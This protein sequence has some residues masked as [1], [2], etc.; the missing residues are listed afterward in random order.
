MEKDA[1]RAPRE[2][3]QARGTKSRLCAVTRAEHP[4][5]NL[6]RFVAGPD[7]R[8]VP[9]LARRLPGRGVWVTATHEMVRMAAERRV[10]ARSLKTE[11]VVDLKLADLVSDLLL[12]R[13]VGLVS[14]ANKAGL[15]VTG[16]TK[17]ERALERGTPT[18]LLHAHEAA[19]DGVNKL[20]HKLTTLLA[21]AGLD[22]RACERRILRFLTN[23][24]LS[25]AIGR[26]N[27]VHAALNAGGASRA[28]LGEA[29]RFLRYRL[30]ADF[31]AAA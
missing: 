19:R 31:E 26:P 23:A 25:L 18:A 3:A 5:Q 16:F 14:L 4:P 15:V 7:G 8:I 6:I 30:G 13:V 24:E 27:V 21:A 22:K 20:D 29:E 10:F 17:I 11:V 9:D 12:K 28:L 2:H 1:A